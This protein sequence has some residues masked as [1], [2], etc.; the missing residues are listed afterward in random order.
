MKVVT[1]G[2]VTI[3]IIDQQC[4]GPDFVTALAC[5]V[6]VAADTATFA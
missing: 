1:A 4:A 6:R 2:R 5:D 3:A